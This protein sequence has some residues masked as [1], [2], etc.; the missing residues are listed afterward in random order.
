MDD[1]LAAKR[2]SVAVGV[3]VWTFFGLT[4]SGLFTGAEQPEEIK[5]VYVPEDERRGPAGPPGPTEEQVNRAVD[6]YCSDGR[7]DDR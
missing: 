6:D 1:W 2:L 3:C 5:I 4:I 7:C